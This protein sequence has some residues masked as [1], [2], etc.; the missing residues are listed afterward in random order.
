MPQYDYQC[1]D[2]GTEF[3]ILMSYT[4]W[5][6]WTGAACESCG[7]IVT[8]ANRIIGRGLTTNVVGSARKGNYGSGD[9]S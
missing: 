8:K 6:E 1:P 3:D 7:A 2:C 4:E 9:W 5:D